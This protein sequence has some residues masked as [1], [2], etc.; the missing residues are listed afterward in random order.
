MRHVASYIALTLCV[1]EVIL[2]LMSWLLSVSFADSSIR[3]LLSSEG[4]RWLFGYYV[5]MLLRPQLI[6]ILL[7]SLSWG[8]Y[9]GSGMGAIFSSAHRLQYRERIALWLVA[10][11]IVLIVTVLLLLTVIP[12]AVLLSV[13]GE[14]FP[15][16]FSDSIVPVLAFSLLSASIVFGIVSGNFH[17]INNVYQSMKLGVNAFAPLFLFYVLI[18][19]LLASFIF[20]FW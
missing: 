20:V 5:D 7:F 9:K 12:H 13:T 11:I 16:P 3:S 10:F 1:A 4:L 19:Q 8:V 18:T 14:L 17:H 6:W 15:S 2:V